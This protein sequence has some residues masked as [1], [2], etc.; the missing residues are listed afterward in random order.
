MVLFNI[1][2]K[3]LAAHNSSLSSH[4]IRS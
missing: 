4:N 1:L 2:P 3:S